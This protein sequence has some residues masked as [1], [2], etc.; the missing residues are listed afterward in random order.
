MSNID[1]SYCIKSMCKLLAET[2]L[3][4]GKPIVIY[5]GLENTPEV[6]Q[7]SDLPVMI[8]DVT[9]PIRFNDSSAQCYDVSFPVDVWYVRS[10]DDGNTPTTDILRK[11][12]ADLAKILHRNK[13]L[14]EGIATVDDVLVNG[15]DCSNYNVFNQIAAEEEVN[16]VAVCVSCDVKFEVSRYDLNG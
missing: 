16:I 11:D 12:G 13:L 3:S 6:K 1:I 14:D 8:V 7:L 4:S 15:I 5:D 10:Q 2:T 9:G